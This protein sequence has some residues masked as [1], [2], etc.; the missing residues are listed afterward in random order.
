MASFVRVTVDNRK[1]ETFRLDQVP[2]IGDVIAIPGGPQVVIRYVKR[3]RRGQGIIAAE[4]RAG[5]A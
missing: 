2:D 4:A 3:R 5:R 1:P